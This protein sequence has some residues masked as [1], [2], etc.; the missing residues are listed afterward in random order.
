MIMTT[1]ANPS[2]EFFFDDA[3]DWQPLVRELRRIML[4]CDVV[5]EL[6][7]G[8]PCYTTDDGNIAIIQTFKNY[9]AVLYP[10]GVLLDDPNGLLVA[11]TKNVQAS[12]QIRFADVAEVLEHEADIRSLT[13]QAIANEAA[14]LDVPMKDTDDFEMV[15]EF[16]ERLASMPELAEAFEALTPGRQRAYLL[17]FAGAKQSKTRAARVDRN[18]ERILAG[19]GLND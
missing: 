10:K 12:R 16:A 11:M 13:A 3:G 4:D 14:G 8:K 2:V 7:W 5:E 1:G 15:D 17:H 6:K 9:C 19:K 18:V